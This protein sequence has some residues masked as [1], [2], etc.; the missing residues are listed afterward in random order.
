MAAGA[1]SRLDV[2]VV[3]AGPT[4]LV[5]AAELH[6]H[7]LSV[8]IVDKAAGPTVWSKAQAI[9]ARTLELLEQLG[10]V[11]RF[12]MRG[13]LLHTLSM[14]TRDGKR[15][16]KVEIGDI[17]SAYPFMLSLPQRDTEE[18][19][20]EYLQELGITVE[21]H[22]RLSDLKQSE[23]EVTA[24]LIHTSA[25]DRPG[26]PR[27]ESQ[28]QVRAAYVVGCD[29]SHST[30]RSLLGIDF[31][32]STY[33]R[34][35]LHADV[36][37]DWPLQHA[38][39]EVVGMV[40]EAGPLGAFPLPPR[41]EQPDERRYRLVAF[42][43]GLAPTLENFQYLLQTRGPVG[44]QLS[45]PLWMTEHSVQCRL[46][47]RFADGRV[48]LAGDAAH[49]HSPVTGHGMN[50]G[51]Q[52]AFNLAWKLALVHKGLGKPVLLD[53]YEAER[54]PVARQ[55][56]QTTDSV[57]RGLQ[58][59]LSLHGSLGQLLR[60]HLLHFVSEL[61]IVQQ[62]ISRNLTML[63]VSYCASPVVHEQFTARALPLMNVGDVEAPWR[64]H[65]WVAVADGPAAGERAR[66]FQ[67]YSQADQQTLRLRQVLP[68]PQHKL[69]LF[70][71]D[72]SN[73]EG[74]RRLAATLAAVGS[75]FG[76]IM[77]PLLIAVHDPSRGHIGASAVRALFPQVPGLPACPLLLDPGGVLHRRYTAYQDSVF[78]IRPDGYVGYRGQPADPEP[79]LLYLCQLFV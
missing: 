73:Q 22:V 28:E 61:G 51:M 9:Q 31:V 42:D 38:E 67:L 74:M 47:G 64:L 24:Q 23:T 54:M 66:D 78:L 56:L 71:G 19:L 5:L 76:R 20:I 62:R 25:A 32:G 52:D 8:R 75:D 35:I 77:Q 79:L 36:R 27:P 48:F 68:G 10:I 65:D 37:I 33:L 72:G 55:L 50:A 49:T 53:S 26:S 11:D 69:L 43:A 70:A 13:Q 14:Y 63:D 44:A 18:L 30:V 17:D 1:P 39:N 60:N 21:R 46:A 4:G 15:L 12:L 16:F 59:W 58:S 40:S 57:T 34:R 3:G 45:A 6:R 2:L 41:P 29:G 7:G